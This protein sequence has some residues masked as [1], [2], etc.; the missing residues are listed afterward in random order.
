MEK[1]EFPKV[2]FPKTAR[3]FPYTVQVEKD[4]KYLW[5]SC[6]LSKNQPFCD[7]SHKVDGIFEPIEYIATETKK[8]KF[9]G[10]KYS[11]SRPIC[12]KT[13]IEYIIQKNEKKLKHPLI[14]VPFFF[15]PTI[16]LV[17][18]YIID[19]YQRNQD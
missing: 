6:G 8:V 3:P 2:H 14:V 1:N 12:D 15:I 11:L 9:C 7:G 10:C 5:C 16:A 13:H 18:Y 19:K 4:K 17:K